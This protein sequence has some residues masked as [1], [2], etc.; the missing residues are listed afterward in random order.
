MK[1]LEMMYEGKAKIYAKQKRQ[2]KLSF[3]IKM[4][5]QHLMVK[6]KVKLKKKVF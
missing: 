3:I 2:M 4:M 5:Q 6:R 1:K